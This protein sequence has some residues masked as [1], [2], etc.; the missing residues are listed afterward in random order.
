M[1]RPV[2]G[3]A[4]RHVT[5]EGHGKRSCFL[6]GLRPKT[7]YQLRVKASGAHEDG[8]VSPSINVTTLDSGRISLLL[9]EFIIAMKAIVSKQQN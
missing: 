1:Y 9:V 5:I 6:S 2:N 7:T 3:G 8:P 4:E